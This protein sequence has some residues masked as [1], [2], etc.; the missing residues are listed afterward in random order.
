MGV[1]RVLLIVSF[2][3]LLALPQGVRAQTDD[4][5]LQERAVPLYIVNGKRVSYAEA[6]DISPRNILLD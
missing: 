3:A 5:V 6:K 1:L 4:A 2:V